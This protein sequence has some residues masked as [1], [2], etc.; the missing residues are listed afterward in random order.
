MSGYYKTYLAKLFQIVHNAADGVQL[1]GILVGNADAEGV[2]KLHY[3][4]DN[5]QRVSSDVV[6]K[7]GVHGD[8]LGVQLKLLCKGLFYSLKYPNNYLQCAMHIDFL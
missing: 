1:G 4:L 6:D 8:G 2:L 7:I 5:V 3:P